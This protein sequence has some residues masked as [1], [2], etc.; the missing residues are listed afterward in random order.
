MVNFTFLKIHKYINLKKS[1]TSHKIILKVLRIK[2]FPELLRSATFK[3]WLLRPF[4]IKCIWAKNLSKKT[5][6]KWNCIHLKAIHTESNA[7][8]CTLQWCH[9]DIYIKILKYSKVSNRCICIILVPI[10]QRHLFKIRFSKL[11]IFVFSSILAHL[12][13]QIDILMSAIL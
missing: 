7:K 5:H 3:I 6:Y 10:W 4:Q 12:K 11:I 8:S 13:P 2:N 9:V 1:K